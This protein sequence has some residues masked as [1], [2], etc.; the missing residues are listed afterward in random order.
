MVSQVK[1]G[2]DPLYGSHFLRRKSS[3]V[4]FFMKKTK[5]RTPLITKYLDTTNHDVL[6]YIVAFLD[7]NPGFSCHI[8]ARGE[9]VK[10]LTMTA[11][12]KAVTYYVHALLQALGIITGRGNR[13]KAGDAQLRKASA[14]TCS[15]SR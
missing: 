6:A 4:N 9:G 5:L 14:V 8:I 1:G 3:M 10:T 2:K 12:K 11:S 13:R 7:R 15:T